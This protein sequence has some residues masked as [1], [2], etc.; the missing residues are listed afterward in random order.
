MCARPGARRAPLARTAAAWRSGSASG[1]HDA[2]TS[3]RWTARTVRPALEAAADVQQARGVA[4]T[5]GLGARSSRCGRSLSASIA[6]ETSALRIANMPA[7]AAALRRVGERA[8]LHARVPPA[9]ATPADRRPRSARSEWH[10]GWYVSG[11]FEATSRRRRPRAGRRGTARAPR[12]A[13]RRPSGSAD[14]LRDVRAHVGGARAGRER[15]PPRIPRTSRR[16]GARARTPRRRSRR[17]GAAGRSRS[18]RAGTRPRPRAAPA[19]RRSPARR[20][21]GACRRGR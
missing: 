18:A 3:A 14:V 4:G 19:A 8:E 1:A 7:E 15:R 5:H 11:A 9:G 2:S 17:S 21:A 6:L 10:V 20:P 13:T 12:S 16:T